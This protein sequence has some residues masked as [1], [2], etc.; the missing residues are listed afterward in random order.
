MVVDLRRPALPGRLPGP[1]LPRGAGLRARR[2]ARGRRAAARAQPGLGPRRARWRAGAR[3]P[4]PL[5]TELAHDGDPVAREVLAAV[6]RRLGRRASSA[7]VNIFN[8]D[9]VVIGGGAFAAGDLLL[10]PAREVLAERALPP[11]RDPLA[12]SPAHFGSEAGMLG[13]AL[14]AL[15]ALD[16]G[17][18]RRP[19]DR[20]P[21]GRL[22][23]ADREPRGRH[24]ARARRRCARP[25]WSPARTRAARARCSTA[26]GSARRS[27]AT[28]STTRSER[29][30]ELV[31]RMR[32]GATVALVS[33]AGMPLVSDPGYVLVRACV[34]AGLPVEVLP[35][36]SAALAA[37]VASALPV[38]PLAL[39]RLPAAQAG[40]AA[41]ACSS[42]PGGTLVAFESPRRRR[43]P[44]WRCWLRSTLSARWR[45]AAS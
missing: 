19:R 34:A 28:T 21:A 24:A 26:T 4:A 20:R 27:S 3:S 45:S 5:V 8:P 38:G 29:A 25:T 7:L 6:G 44:R 13:A 35:G 15:D 36:P 12:S 18:D 37:L 10:E 16:A 39:R 17:G 31:E 22:P 30:A 32:A 2:S 33:D 42:E 43:R 41:R 23:D 40:R 1:R 9:L 11:G 14:L